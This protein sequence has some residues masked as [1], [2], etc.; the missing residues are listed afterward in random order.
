M[1]KYLFSPFKLGNL[2]L[3]N[4]IAMAPLTRGRAG[5]N[6]T[7]NQ[8]M[9]QYYEMRASAGLIIAEATAMSPQGYGWYASSALYS[10]DHAAGWRQVVDAVHNKG[11]KI[12]TQA[13]HMGRQAHSSF[14]ERKEIVAASAIAV[15][16]K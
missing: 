1:A 5:I 9:R 12:F 4:R 2:E 15:P 13:W 11:G 10:D 7:A 16:G 8:Y 6:R 3:A 14:N